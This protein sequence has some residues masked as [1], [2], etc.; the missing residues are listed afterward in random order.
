MKNTKSFTLIEILVV[1]IIVGILASLVLFSTNDAFDK[2]KRMEVLNFSNSN[3]G[4]IVQYLVSEWAF[5]G[6]TIAGST[7]TNSDVKDSWGHNHGTIVGDPKIREGDDCI[8]GKCLELDGS[9]YINFGQGAGDSLK[10]T[11]SQTFEMWLYPT[12]FAARRNPMAK[13]YGGEG[14]ITQETNKYLT[15]YYGTY[16]GNTSPYQGVGSGKALIAN[17]WNYIAVVRDLTVG[18]MKITWFV[19]GE[20]G[21]S[22]T[23]SY[24]SATSSTLNFYIGTGYCSAQIGRVDEIR[25]YDGPFN[26]ANAKQNYIAGLNSMLESGAIAKSDYNQRLMSLSKN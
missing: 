21:T 15:Y 24:A 10:I 18:K 4:Q 11:G 1:I 23:A 9:D 3:K 12:D 17:E 2:Q 8:L 13:A 6:P 26:L 14:T 20:Q 7:A 16:G 5:E 19:N 22:T 25:I